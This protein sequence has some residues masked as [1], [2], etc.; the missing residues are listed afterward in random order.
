M[1]DRLRS[2]VEAIQEPR[3]WRSSP[4]GLRRAEAYVVAELE[5]LGLRVRREP[6]EFKGRHFENIVASLDP[7]AS[8]PRQLIGAHLDT[9]PG[10]PGA[11]DNG[12]GLAGI[13]EAARDLIENPPTGPVDFA[14]F[15]RRPA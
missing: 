8:S 13:I 7:G 2:H 12:S 5:A 4:E 6:F 15:H 14:A 3:D 1:I 9:V 11:N 10:S